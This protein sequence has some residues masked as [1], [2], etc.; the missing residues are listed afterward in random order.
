MIVQWYMV[1]GECYVFLLCTLVNDVNVMCT[2]WTVWM[3][4]V[5]GEWYECYVFMV[6]G[7]NVMCTC[8]VHG[9]WYE[10]YVFMVNGMNVMCSWYVN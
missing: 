7:M 10:C 4:C 6:N 3:L 9:E 1:N 8:C 2:W 5:H